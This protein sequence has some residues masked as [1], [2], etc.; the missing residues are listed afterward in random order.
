MAQMSAGDTTVGST[1]KGAGHGGMI[2]LSETVMSRPFFLTCCIRF[3][4]WIF[5]IRQRRCGGCNSA[6]KTTAAC[7]LASA[8]FCSNEMAIPAVKWRFT[9]EDDARVK[10]KRLYPAVSTWL[11]TR[12][13][14][15]QILVSLNRQTE[16]PS[17]C[18][19]LVLW[20]EISLD[21]HPWSE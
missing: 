1:P 18:A 15:A 10:L 21:S 16:F 13:G 2:S 6:A 5:S 11:T 14:H 7:R 12:L 4:V 9:T 20:T 8:N 3:T 19:L 17:G